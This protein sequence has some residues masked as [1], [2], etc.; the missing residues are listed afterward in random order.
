MTNDLVTVKPGSQARVNDDF[1]LARTN[2][3]DTIANAQEAIATVMQLAD[4]SQSPRFYEVLSSLLKTSV[5]ANKELLA[6]QKSVREVTKGESTS[7]GQKTINNNLIIT[8]EELR[9]II[10]GPNVNSE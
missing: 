7:G 1:E 6:L 9:K 4:Q 10:K 3:M 8:T 5:D 2:L